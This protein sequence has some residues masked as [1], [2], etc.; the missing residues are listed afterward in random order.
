M[1]EEVLKRDLETE[2]REVN[3]LFEERESWRRL[4]KKKGDQIAT[5]RGHLEGYA[6]GL[7]LE[8][9]INRK[10]LVEGLRED[11]A[12]LARITELKRK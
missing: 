1:S 5:V 7:G 9:E 6:D 2:M 11:A 4:A 8:I 3:R 12:A 10:G